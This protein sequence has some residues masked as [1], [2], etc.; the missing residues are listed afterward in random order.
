MIRILR[1][2]AGGKGN[3]LIGLEDR[4]FGPPAGRDTIPGGTVPRDGLQPGRS[5][6]GVR[7]GRIVIRDGWRRIELN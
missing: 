4:G 5:E 2:G 6:E 7:P 3:C 1:Q